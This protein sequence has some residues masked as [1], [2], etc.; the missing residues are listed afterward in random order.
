MSTKQN[1][2][3]PDHGT[4]S[5]DAV[6]FYDDLWANT[7]RIDQHHKCRILAIERVLEKLLKNNAGSPQILELGSGSGIV[8]EVLAKYG[9]VTGVDQSS[10]G[11][12][13]SRKNI[14]NGTFMVGSLPDIPVSRNDF[15]VCIMTQVIEH[16][17][18]SAQREVL[19]NILAKV[20]PGG[21]LIVTTPNKPVS[22]AMRFARGEL[23]PIENWFN[24]TELEELLRKSGWTVHETTFA[25]SFFPI[26]S[27]RS[28]VFR[29]LRY[30]TY[31]LIYLRRLI[32]GVMSRYPKGDTIVTVAR[33]PR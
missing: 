18:E 16:L 3:H 5:V 23:Q 7:S 12:D 13:I 8:A 32:E 14:P 28:F 17:S 33:R 30:L 19:K 26:M 1:S 15:D 29:G 27:S 24:A 10:V 20:K 9:A 25:F 11:V 31:D 4:A 21:A 6:S 2:S 22:N